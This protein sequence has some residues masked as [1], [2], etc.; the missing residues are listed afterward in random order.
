MIPSPDQPK[1]PPDLPASGGD[2]EPSPRPAHPSPTVCLRGP[3]RPGNGEPVPVAGN[4]VAGAPGLCSPARPGNGEPVPVAP[5]AAPRPQLPGG[6]DGDGRYEVFGEIARGGMGAVLRGRDR[7][8]GRDL[9]IKVLLDRHRDRPDLECRFLAEARVGARLQHPGVVPVYEL[10]RAGDRPFFTMKLVEGRTLADLLAARSAPGDDLARLLAVFEQVCQALAYAHSLGVLHRDLKPSNIMV[11][12]FGEVQVMDWGLAKVLPRGEAGAG[13][14]A[15]P[16]GHES[17]VGLV[18][19]TPAYV[20]PEQARG[21]AD[22]VDERADVF[23]LGAILC[24]ILTGKPPH[25][26]P[27]TSG[28]FEMA[29]RGD[30]AAALARLEG[31]GA[32][33]ELVALA[34]AC[35]CSDPAGRP[36]DAGAVARAVMDYR[37]GVQER[38]RQAE[39]ERAAAQAR[40]RAERKARRLKASLAALL[41]VALLGSVAVWMR[42]VSQESELRHAVEADLDVA[43][44]FLATGNRTESLAA[45][46]RAE[47][48]LAGGG[49]ADLRRRVDDL[50]AEHARYE[51]DRDTIG[52]LEEARL[53][54]AAE[55]DG[56]F[57]R[58]QGDPLFEEAFRSYGLDRTRLKPDEAAALIRTSAIREVL[59]AA[60]MNWF[61]AKIAAGAEGREWVEAVLDLADP[62]EWRPRFRAAHVHGD[63][64]ELRRLAR[65]PEIAREPPAVLVL[66]ADVMTQAG[67]PDAAVE[68]LEPAQRRYPQDF[69][70][71]EAL[72]YA[73]IR[74]PRTPGPDRFGE[75]IACLRLAAALKPDSPGAHLNLGVAL[76]EQGRLAAGEAAYRDALKCKSDYV[77]ALLNLGVVQIRQGRLAE[78]ADNF[79]EV[80]RLQPRNPEGVY[81]LGTLR[82]MEERPREAV[83]LLE[84]ARQLRP[85]HLPT[86]L[87]CGLALLQT[88]NLP[89]AAAAYREAARQAPTLAFA[90]FNLG[91]VLGYQGR[92]VE[93]EAAFREAIRLQAGHAE[94]HCN[95]GHTL[96]SLGRLREGL[97]SLRRGHQLGSTRAGWQYPSS[98]WVQEAETLVRLEEELPALTAGR[99]GPPPDTREQLLRAYLCLIKGYPA[100][101][102][103]L[104]AEAFNLHP[105]LAIAAFGDPRLHASRAAALAGC[106]RGNDGAALAE[107][108]RQRW[109]RQALAW[110]EAD[111]FVRRQDLKGENRSQQ[112]ATRTRLGTWRWHADLAPL[113]EPAEL[114]KLPEDERRGWQTLLA[115][116]D[117]LL[118]FRNP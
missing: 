67:V 93:A 68:L 48:R 100:A 62:K 16:P 49:S 20:A 88:G 28:T 95:L 26:G 102:A 50:L 6:L 53:R 17:Q 60:L 109:R 99:A 97:Q 106:G 66:L 27:T 84:K 76:V 2:N 75:G 57:D 89:A 94:A 78:A 4:P 105:E 69:W 59:V 74:L 112:A 61:Y 23:G 7:H 3:A 80:I 86:Q 101:A 104:Y 38:L 15:E 30:V 24:E 87:S 54:Q 96:L 12:A 46:R 35:L 37:A 25:I 44:R 72:G 29:A 55:K 45:T 42:R 65:L 58:S 9:A 43:E 1:V 39:L 107:P 36:R 33:P 11:G 81:N 79:R 82:L 8:L 34:R 118:D 13:P 31:C 70:I 19:G 10:G 56:Q 85:N 18:L 40:A 114:Q 47:G 111:C 52:R 113:R 63:R 22:R 14:K 108:E 115:S 91:N 21:E 32:D 51:K 92:M 110:I 83:V 90:F 116:L 77:T 5:N 41:L 73:L 117:D 64:E 103:R 71:H 98:R